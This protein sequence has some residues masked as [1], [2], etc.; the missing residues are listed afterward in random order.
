MTTQE[1]T[2]KELRKQI[3]EIERSIANLDACECISERNEIMALE[4]Q[5]AQIMGSI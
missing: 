2:I 3:E 1:Q 4:A 5:I